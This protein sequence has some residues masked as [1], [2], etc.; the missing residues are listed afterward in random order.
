MLVMNYKF[1]FNLLALALLGFTLVDCATNQVED[2]AMRQKIN[3]KLFATSGRELKPTETYE[4]LRLL[5]RY[6]NYIAIESKQGREHEEVKKLIKLAD[7]R[8]VHCSYLDLSDYDKLAS[9]KYANSINLVAYLKHYKLLAFLSCQ[10]VLEML[11]ESEDEAEDELESLSKFE[12]LKERIKL[13]N[14]KQ[15][16]RSK[17]I[18]SRES[19]EEGIKGLIEEDEKNIGINN[20]LE[21]GKQVAA[22][23]CDD[24]IER[25]RWSFRMF[26]QVMD[27]G[28]LLEVLE[29]H[30]FDM[31]VNVKIC[32]DAKKIWHKEN[33]S[34]I[35]DNSEQT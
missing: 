28:E 4:L 14:N 11:I 15:F 5:D 19:L 31:L 12:A 2:E 20:K 27:E 17:P 9:L 34:T 13:A 6:Y 29:P 23:L 24:V 21:H 32:S 1:Y 35:Y 18:Y 10:S 30:L 16:N 26:Q 3:S 22:A 8:R 33:T 7:I 25:H